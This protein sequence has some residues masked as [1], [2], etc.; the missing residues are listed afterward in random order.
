MT[1]IFKR[2][3]KELSKGS[4]PSIPE[5]QGEIKDLKSQISNLEDQVKEIHMEVVC[6]KAK[7]LNDE[8]YSKFKGKS[9]VSSKSS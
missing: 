8:F 3:Q 4:K 9:K 1:N 2:A 6:L 5:L 7:N